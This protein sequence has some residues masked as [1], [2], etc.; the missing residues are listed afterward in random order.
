MPPAI[1]S[2]LD[3]D[4]VYF[5]WTLARFLPQ[6]VKENNR[7]AIVVGTCYPFKQ[8]DELKVVSPTPTDVRFFPDMLS[9]MQLGP[10]TLPTTGSIVRRD[11]V[12]AAG[13]FQ[14]RHINQTDVDLWL[15]LGT[16]K[17]FVRLESPPMAG[18]REH[19]SNISGNRDMTIAGANNLI[20]REK[21]NSYPGGAYGMRERLEYML[22]DI[23]LITRLPCAGRFRG[24]WG[25]YA[26]CFN[27]HLKLRRFK[28]LVGFPLIAVKTWLTPR[29]AKISRT[30][31][32]VC[33]AAPSIRSTS[34]AVW[35]FN[36][37]WTNFDLAPISPQVKKANF[38]FRIPLPDKSAS[39][40][41]HSHTLE[42]LSLKFGKQF[43]KECQRVL[44]SRA[45]SCALSFLILR[46]QCAI[47]ST[48]SIAAAR[49]K[50]CSSSICG[51]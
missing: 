43:L 40:V 16:S 35:R 7:P 41:Y 12:E 14:E 1:S 45:E 31:F 15:R 32:D 27:W 23:R 38:L 46:K 11:L 37:N 28:Y 6:V 51:C 47:T 39:C 10:Q 48:S 3:S 44:S 25:L 5:P 19:G 18:R 50:I 30:G 36:P 17:G 33:K 4:D 26:S 49:A 2:Y 9:L 20:D 29:P 8:M 24:A 22:F 21:S 34:A 42:H 13:L